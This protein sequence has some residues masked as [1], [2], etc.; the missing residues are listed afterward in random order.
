MTTT[1]MMHAPII[2]PI[3]SRFR[4]MRAA[5][6]TPTATTGR[7][8]R[9]G[10]PLMLWGDPGVAK[11][12]AAR[13]FG[14]AV[15]AAVEVFSPGER[16]EAA[17][18]VVPVPA[19]DGYL[20]TPLPRWAEKF[21]RADGYGLLVLDELPTADARVQP[22]MMAAIME[23]TIG[24]VPFG[25]RVRVIATG[26]P[27]DQTPG[28]HD[29][30]LPL[31]NRLIHLNWGHPT[32]D[33]FNMYMLGVDSD[34]AADVQRD[35]DPAA[36]EAD[37]LRRWPAAFSAAKAKVGAFLAAMPQRLH[38]LPESG[39]TGSAQ[40]WASPRSWD[41]ATRAIAGAE[42]HGL[43]I[44]ETTAMI[45][46]CVGASTARE[47]TVYAAKLDLPPAEKVLSGEVAWDAATDRLDRV[48]AVLMGVTGFVLSLPETDP[49]FNTLGPRYW[50]LILRVC[51]STPDV[52]LRFAGAA[53]ARKGLMAAG[54][55]S[56]R[57]FLDSDAM[58][59]MHR[60]NKTGVARVP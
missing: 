17:I 35:A 2:L 11:T 30:A 59:V 23:R 44:D 40:A 56:G 33:E 45:A 7:G 54:G 4:V 50:A 16:G 34:T 18:G 27:P 41:L 10:L 51:E 21:V 3:A 26:N 15:R 39:A 43:N 46:G 29:L 38:Q 13:Q 5:F 36:V 48:R 53:A 19:A 14:D 31:A 57:A 32:V 52:A 22:G 55:L 25:G 28:G 60:L 49:R 8:I 12:S 58:K 47:F 37:V 24:G 42:I 1:A 20:D 9:M 6:Y